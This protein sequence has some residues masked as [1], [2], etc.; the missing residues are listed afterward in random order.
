M[1][2]L[3][4]SLLLIC[5]MSIVAFADGIIIGSPDLN[6]PASTTLI[7]ILESLIASVPK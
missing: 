5:A 2:K 3:I 1:K 4:A 6:A 7:V